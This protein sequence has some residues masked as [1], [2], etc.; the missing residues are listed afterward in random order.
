MAVSA[1]VL[2][3]HE[4]ASHSKTEGLAAKIE[5]VV[6]GHPRHSGVAKPPVLS[7]SPEVRWRL[8]GVDVFEVARAWW[9]P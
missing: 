1:R 8:R 7:K 5:G 9:A 2:P 3:G 4:H 6:E